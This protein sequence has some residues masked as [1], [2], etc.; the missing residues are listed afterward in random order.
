MVEPIVSEGVIRRFGRATGGKPGDA[1]AM[2]FGLTGRDRIL[3]AEANARMESAQ[4]VAVFR[5][6]VYPSRQLNPDETEML[7]DIKTI[8]HETAGMYREV[9]HEVLENYRSG[10]DGNPLTPEIIAKLSRKGYD[11]PRFSVYHGAKAV[12]FLDEA[13][14]PATGLLEKGDNFL[15]VFAKPKP[16]DRFWYRDDTT[17]GD[18][19]STP[20][21]AIEWGHFSRQVMPVIW[22]MKDFQ[23]P[24]HNLQFA[25]QTNEHTPGLYYAWSVGRMKDWDIWIATEYYG[26]SDES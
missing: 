22:E 19:Q 10:D 6:P 15:V 2:V 26:N 8:L 18:M 24:E 11:L 5:L 1:E 13:G 14:V 4:E 21:G 12:R 25:R 20:P 17:F 23:A 16:L 9:M 3:E 7:D